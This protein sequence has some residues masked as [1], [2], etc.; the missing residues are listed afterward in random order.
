[1]SDSPSVK[2]RQSAIDTARWAAV[3]EE[4]AL[5]ARAQYLEAVEACQG[6]LVRPE[7]AARVGDGFALWSGSGRWAWNRATDEL[8]YFWFVNGRV[9]VTAFRER[10]R[11]AN[12]E[13][14]GSGGRASPFT[15]R[16]G[17]SSA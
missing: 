5:A 11:A 15:G 4:W 12:R 6:N 16:P 9:T 3:R 13:A 8:R 10:Q 7:F 2:S 1:V 17:S 14:T